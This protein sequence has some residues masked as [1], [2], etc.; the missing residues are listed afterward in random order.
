MPDDITK[1]RRPDYWINANI[2]GVRLGDT[3]KTKWDVEIDGEEDKQVAAEILEKAAY[4]LRG[5]GE[6]D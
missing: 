3:G 4:V 1:R 2:I 6:T 5:Q